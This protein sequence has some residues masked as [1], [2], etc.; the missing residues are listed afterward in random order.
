MIPL[1]DEIPT[2]RFPV[3][4]AS[5][6]VIN[7]LVFIYQLGLSQSETQELMLR[8][9]FIPALY[10]GHAQLPV[11]LATLPGLSII[12]SMFMHGG[13]MHVA[14]N[15][16]YLWIF[17]DNIEDYLGR[18]KFVIFYLVSGLAAVG[19]FTLTSWGSTVP[20]IGAS[21]A[22][23][24]I[25]GAYLVLYPHARVQTLIF[26]FFI[27][28]IQVP[29]KILLGF[30]FIMQLLYGL[31][32]LALNGAQGGGVAWFAHVGGFAFG[33]AYFRFTGKRAHWGYYS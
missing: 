14:G 9:A 19:L 3:V 21:G 33:Y 32:E 22:I 18:V 26:F 31:P 5:F 12:T 16:L 13:F 11:G 4:T 8:F 23:A 1:K 25:L 20:L 17:G 24:G 28:R 10:T 29:A 30:W 7:L 15:M 27:T 2:R 6:I